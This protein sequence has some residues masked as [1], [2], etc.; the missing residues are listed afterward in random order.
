MTINKINIKKTLE[1]VSNLLKEEKTLS[2]QVRAMITLLTVV[3]ELLLGKLGLNSS[4]SS[5]PPS[6]DPNRKR[7]TTNG[8]KPKSVGGQH[9]HPGFT[10]VK[11][12]S[13][14]VIKEIPVDRALLP[15]GK[16]KFVRFESRQVV[17]IEISRVVTE[18]RAEVVEDANGKQFTASFPQGVSKA[19]Q[20][21]SSVKAKG[22]YMSVEQMLPFERTSEY[23]KNQCSI[24]VST[25]SLVSFNAEAYEKLGEFE[26]IV[27]LKLIQEDVLNADETSINLNGTNIWLHTASSDLWTL[28]YPHAKRGSDAMEEMGV[29]KEFKGILCHDHWKPYFMF[30]CLHALCNA[31]HLRELERA[32]E[33]DNQTWAK[34]MQ[35]LLLEINQ[36]KIEHKGLIPEETA[37]TFLIRYREVL[38]NADEECPAPTHKDSGKRGRLAKS[39]S[40][41]L[42]ERLRDFETETLRF[43]YKVNVPFTN[44]QGE[45]DIRMTKVQQKISGSFRSMEGAKAF[46]RIRSYL[47]TCKKHG[48]NPTEAL[49]TLFLGKL[50]DFLTPP[51]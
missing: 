4:N 33:Q 49:K 46:C 30:Q 15:K 47:S 48:V 13:P 19:I 39:K 26:S 7:K 31:H 35:D 24:G 43:M 16:Y 36:S 2:P 9:G 34:T 38:K 18:Y 10:L 44:N 22:V 12:A 37:A 25:G 28:F 23:F 5:L 11:E 50:P 21:G 42:L 40:R 6:R 17:D 45:R 3:I 8:D 27:K 41:N 1:D 32:A 14:D 51:P 20:Y 29:L